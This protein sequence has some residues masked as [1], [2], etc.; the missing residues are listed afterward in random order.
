[1]IDP[2]SGVRLER[3]EGQLVPIDPS[4]GDVLRSPPPADNELEFRP[5]S[6]SLIDPVDRISY[7]V[8][9]GTGRVLEG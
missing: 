2:V 6:H 7:R 5:D 9:Y 4:T 3:F 8:D 1:M